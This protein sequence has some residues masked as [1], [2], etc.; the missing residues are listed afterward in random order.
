MIF[1]DIVKLSFI[2]ISLSF[3]VVLVLFTLNMY[4]KKNEYRIYITC[5]IVIAI[6]ST[7]VYCLFLLFS[8]PKAHF[9]AVLF[10]SL[11]FIGTD[12]LAMSML[13]FA[14]H[15]TEILLGYGK[16][17]QIAC[18][19]VCLIDS[20]SLIVNN[21]THHMFDLV[22]TQGV[23][24]IYYWGNVFYLCHYLHLCICYVMV[25]ATF[26]L[27]GLVTMQSPSFYK[28]KYLGILIAYFV[29]IDVNMISYSKDLP[30]DISVI[31]YV[32][33]AGFICHY[34]T[35]TYPHKLLNKS[36]KD[37]NESISDAILYFDKDGVCVYANR[38]ARK[39][40]SQEKTGRKR[41][42]K[43]YWDPD[44]NTVTVFSK[45]KA[46]EF[47]KNVLEKLEDKDEQKL[48]QLQLMQNKPVEVKPLIEAF[49][50]DGETHYYEVEYKK[51]WFQNFEIGCY[52]NL[53]DKTVSVNAYE[54]EK[55]TATHDDLTGILNRV[56]FCEAVDES[57]RK[58]GLSDRVMA[59]SDIKDF[60]LINELF[61]DK[62]GDLVLQRQAQILRKYSHE[63]T[64]YGRIGDDKFAVYM[65]K[66]NFS[67]EDLLKYIEAM[68]KLTDSPI[69]QMH[70]YTGIY[71]PIGRLESAQEM[72]DK[73]FMAIDEIIGDYSEVFSYYDSTLME[74][75][76]EEK[77]IIEAFPKAMESGQIEM[78]L[79]PIID[80]K[81]ASFGA[82]ALCRWNHPL[83]GFLLPSAFLSILEKSGLI[84]QLD[85]F[86]WNKAAEKLQEWSKKGF[87][88]TYIS[89]NISVKD[90][91]YTDIYEFFTQLVKKYEIKP[92][93]LHLEITETVLMS[94]FD[95]VF[96]LS[97]KL[98]K[99]G[100]KVSIDNFGNGYSSLNM[101]KDIKADTLK[102]DMS[103]LKI[104]TMEN[105]NQI[106]LETVINMAKSLDMEVIGEGVETKEQYDVL[107][108][109]DC[110]KYQGNYLAK[111]L[112]VG[113]YE[114]QFTQFFYTNK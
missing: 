61:S 75:R 51:E 67:E 103:F 88:D 76:L 79:Q 5:P 72:C 66:E 8:S 50:I 65:K 47:R 32:F 62:T 23:F 7:I 4:R 82:E 35:Y 59:C 86:I 81:N 12:W 39:I 2:I 77:N 94:D 101:L 105:R 54:K 110:V 74:K 1:P 21:W 63:D 83:R 102:V 27:F 20:I 107:R 78:F 57:I 14:M 89:V 98:Q 48:M 104:A 13:V 26:I 31:L 64:I 85:E 34:S 19:V 70:V 53:I 56:G 49:E 15:Y 6:F 52:F 113:E 91:F 9:Q 90:F 68:K 114:K 106:I 41:K 3:S 55:Y 10:D 22:Y 99:F 112:S 45:R 58:N 60:K 46:E 87:N 44:K 96:S 25:G 24:G 16:S 17:I 100:F 109:Y 29:V 108:K 95:K 97:E 84:F 37:V 69:Y 38:T 42:N 73:C 36:L 33:L 30:L 40:F 111:P 43:E 93:N 28:E 80:A 18:G 71:E 92:E 11:F